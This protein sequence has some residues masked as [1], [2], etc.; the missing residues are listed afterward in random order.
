M[1]KRNKREFIQLLSN[2]GFKLVR[3]RGDH[4][5]WKRNTN[6]MVVVPKHEVNFMI[7][8]RLIKGYKLKEV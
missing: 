7:Q 5:I 4:E 8:H 2:N 1:K 6:E 3:T